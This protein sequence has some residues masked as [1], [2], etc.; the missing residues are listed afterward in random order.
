M[1][2]RRK[3]DDM[4]QAIV[5]WREKGIEEFQRLVMEEQV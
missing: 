2:N 4:K 3:E 1:D 5:E